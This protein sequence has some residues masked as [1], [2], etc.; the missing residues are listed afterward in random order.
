MDRVRLSYK[1]NEKVVLAHF[2]NGKIADTCAK[3]IHFGYFQGDQDDRKYKDKKMLVAETSEMSYVGQN[4]GPLASTVQR[5]CKYYVGVLDKTTGKMR[6]CD[7]EIFQ[8][9]PKPS[10]IDDDEEKLVLP[11]SVSEKSFKEQNDMLTSA[12]GSKKKQRALESRLKN[13]IKGKALDKALSSVISQASTLKPVQVEDNDTN[14][15]YA[16]IPPMNKEAATPRE[17]YNMDDIVHPNDKQSTEEASR[18]FFDATIDDI[19]Q[20]RKENKYPQQILSLLSRMSKS[21]ERRTEQ[22]IYITYLYYLIHLH[23][24]KHKQLREKDPLPKEWPEPVRFHILKKFTQ[25][26]GARQRVFT[27]RLKD[28]LVSSILVLCLYLEEFSMDLTSLQKDLNKTHEKLTRHCQ[29]L[30]CTTKSKKLDTD[31]GGLIE[32]WATLSLPLNLPPQKGGKRKSSR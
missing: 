17:V 23:N 28:K 1:K 32:R 22:A 13:Q 16:I 10:D 31:D 30:G 3:K 6:I 26:V 19:Q 27:A 8:M 14:P 20:W 5:N 4:Y 11:S 18:V 9:H 2:T 7:A 25:G 24:L 12:F 15:D 29:V 21:E